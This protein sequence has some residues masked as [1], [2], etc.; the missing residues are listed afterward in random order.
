MKA[1]TWVGSLAGL[2]LVGL[3]GWRV[4]Q[5]MTAQPGGGE[6]REGGVTTVTT[7]LPTRGPIRDLGVFH[8]GLVARSEF[9]VSPRI[10]GRVLELLADL[11][12]TVTNGQ[13]LARLDDADLIQ[14]EAEAR[15]ALEVA[16]AGIEEV[17]SD[18]KL[19]RQDLAR[20][21]EL[22]GRNMISQAEYETAQ[23]RVEAQ[24][25][26]AKLAEA[27][28]AQRRAALEAARLRRSYA[29]V[30]AAWSGG[31]DAARHVGRRMASAGQN[32]RAGDALFLLVDLSPI[33]AVF[34]VTEKD[35]ARLRPGQSVSIAVDAWP[36]RRFDGVVA[37]IAPRFDASS[38]QARVEVDAPNDDGLLKPGQFVSGFVEFARIEDAWLAPRAAL[39]RR[40]GRAG[41]FVAQPDNTT[42]R[43][44]PVTVGIAD[45]NAVQILEPAITGRVV[46]L[47]H[48]LL[49]DGGRILEAGAATAGA[50]TAAGGRPGG[51]RGAER[52]A[53]R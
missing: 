36:G 35:Y 24:A 5:H 41:V 47:G 39:V 15:A 27:Q 34:D 9:T 29:D 26:R 28:A 17:H 51:P 4:Y 53:E 7:A 10:E 37:R 23:A 22:R 52:G 38:R 6:R 49:E 19:A 8:G 40:D 20:A 44:V 50:P 32:V 2:A 14:V 25:A 42:A 45:T 33:T 3:L 1:G 43:F 16:A 30:R 12:D 11:G 48:H 13:I 21:G 31:G 18:L 46:T